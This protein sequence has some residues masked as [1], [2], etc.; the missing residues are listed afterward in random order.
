M[1]FNSFIREKKVII[2][3]PDIKQSK[4]LNMMSKNNLKEIKKFTITHENS[5][6]ILS[7]AYEC[8]RQILEAISLLEG[9]KVYS[10]EAYKY[11]LEE[12]KE[13]LI[14]NKFDR[15]RRLRN[16]I[17]YYGKPVSKETTINSIKEIEDIILKLEKKYIVV[18]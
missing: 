16:G 17:N 5:S 15:L 8:L 10:H 13:I 2:T 11:F 4:S 7:Q 9:Y 3:T 18:N 1:D 12:K 14:S 6:I